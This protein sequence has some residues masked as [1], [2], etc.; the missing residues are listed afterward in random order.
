MS[1]SGGRDRLGRGLQILGL[2][3]FPVALY[4]GIE[5]DDIWSEFVVAGMGMALLMMGRSLRGA[6]K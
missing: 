2:C 1:N 5:Q 3:L 6:P 4:I